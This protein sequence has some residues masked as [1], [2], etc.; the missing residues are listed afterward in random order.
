MDVGWIK[1]SSRS[2]QLE[3]SESPMLWDIHMSPYI[4]PADSWA[5]LNAV[6]ELASRQEKQSRVRYDLTN[7]PSYRF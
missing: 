3:L 1:R 5:V 2:R 6:N 4:H 7:E